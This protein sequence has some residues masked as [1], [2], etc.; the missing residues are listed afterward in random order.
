MIGTRAAGTVISRRLVIP[1]GQ[2]V[3]KGN[4]ATM[5]MENGD[6][7]GLTEDWAK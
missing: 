7:L 4:N 1:I 5:L 6:L 3:V 2:G